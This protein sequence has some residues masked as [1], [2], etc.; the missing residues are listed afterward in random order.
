M[1]TKSNSEEMVAYDFSNINCQ[2]T[3]NN[4]CFGSCDC[5]CDGGT[6]DCNCDCDSNDCDCNDFCDND[7]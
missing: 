5:N 4:N 1:K 6:C 3:G 7:D 2:E